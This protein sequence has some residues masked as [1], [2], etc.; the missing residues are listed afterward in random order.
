MDDTATG[1]AVEALKKS[2]LDCASW[3]DDVLTEL[4]NIVLT[5]AEEPEREFTDNELV[6]ATKGDNRLL[7]D[8]AK[9]ELHRRGKGPAPWKITGIDRSPTFWKIRKTGID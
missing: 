6:E 7:A 9:W 8:M 2:E 5:A 4:V 3:D 1:R